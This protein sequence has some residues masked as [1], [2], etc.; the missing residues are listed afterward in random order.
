M[1]EKAIN[2]I[3]KCNSL[4]AL[5]KT[6]MDNAGPWSQLPREKAEF[7]IQLKESKKNE[8]KSRIYR[9]TMTSPILGEVELIFNQDEPGRAMVDGCEY[10][11]TELVNLK[12]RNLSPDR[13]QKI[14][15]MKKEFGG[16]VI[17]S[18]QAEEIEKRAYEPAR[19]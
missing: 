18:G 4:E 11:N 17:P 10:S 1:L 5:Q 7:L 8:L 16:Q 19:Q 14:H 3:E 13:L 2:Q 15:Q 9:R 6:W 12:S